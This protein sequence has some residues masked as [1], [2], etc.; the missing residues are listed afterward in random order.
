MPVDGS[1]I[2]NLGVEEAIKLAKGQ[3][4]TLR[5]IHVIDE[6]V[7]MSGDGI[8]AYIEDPL[9]IMREDGKRIVE[10]AEA[11]VKKHGINTESIILESIVGNTAKLIV[12][13][14]KEWGAELIVLGTHGRRGIKRLVMGS[15]AEEIVRMSAIPV[16]F[17]SQPSVTDT[18]KK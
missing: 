8:P 6:F 9:K 13:H 10:E 3:G 5:L 17:V 4:D 14:A 15:D 1:A 2:S 16:L 11:R 7:L 12:D 18:E